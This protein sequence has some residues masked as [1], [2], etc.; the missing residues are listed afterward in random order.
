MFSKIYGSRFNEEELARK[1]GRPQLNKQIEVIKPITMK[2][3]TLFIQRSVNYPKIA[4]SNLLF[5][6]T[7]KSKYD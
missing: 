6:E 3:M 2:M 4:G 1:S 5:D 7:S